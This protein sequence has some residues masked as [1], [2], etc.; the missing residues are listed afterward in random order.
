[1]KILQ[2]DAQIEKMIADITL[3]HYQQVMRAARKPIVNRIREVVIEAIKREPEYE[4][5]LNGRLLG[6]FGLTGAEQ[7]LA[8]ILNVWAQDIHIVV[9][10]K[11]IAI[12][13]IGSNFE[14]VLALPEAR[15]ITEKGQSL[16]WLD[17]LLI[18]G[19]K[20]I[21]KEYTIKKSFNKDSRTGLAVMVE[22]KKGKWA[23]PSQYS[24]TP[25][26]NWVTRAIRNI[27]ASSIE[28]VIIQEVTSRW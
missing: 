8:T 14:D 5:L 6:E 19:D 11:T 18:Q 21:I 13:V 28:E 10:K 2:T 17:W 15:Q 12:T 20:T 7:K 26:D 3:E 25:R 22:S 16:E 24:G 4:S 9:A 27:H 23:V 1:M